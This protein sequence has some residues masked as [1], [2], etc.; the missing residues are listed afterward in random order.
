[1]TIHSMSSVG[2]APILPYMV[3]CARADNGG[4]FDPTTG[5][6]AELHT[7]YMVGG[8]TTPYVVDVGNEA[9]MHQAAKWARE[10]TGL[11]DGFYIGAWQTGETMVWEVSQ[12]ILDRTRAVNAGSDRGEFSVWDLAKGEQIILD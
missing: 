2:P 12:H 11:S 1:M 7:G 4:T 10:D 6:R 9:A 3:S 8:L 5:K